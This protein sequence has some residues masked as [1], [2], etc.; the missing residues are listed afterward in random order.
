MG[1]RALIVLA[2]AVLL[3]CGPTAIQRSESDTSGAVPSPTGATA[4]D[5]TDLITLRENGSSTSLVTRRVAS[6]EVVREIPDGALVPD[7]S[8][9]LTIE[10]GMSAMTVRKVDRRTG[11]TLGRGTVPG[12]WSLDQYQGSPASTSS[13]GRWFV[14]GGNRYNAFDDAA[15]KWIAHT[16]FAVVD[17]KTWRS[18]VIPFEGSYTF[19]AISNSGSSLYLAERTLTDTARARLRVYDMASGTLGDVGGD[20]IPD[21]DRYVR[22]P[23]AF[24]GGM[25]FQLFAQ[26]HQPVLLRLDVGGRQALVLPLPDIT[27]AP[28][29]ESFVMWSLLGKPDGSRLYAVNAALGVIDEIDPT[30]FTLVRSARI[31]SSS[32][33]RIPLR[34]LIDA[35]HPVAYAKRG[36]GTGAVF[37]PDGRTLFAVGQTG[38]WAIDTDSLIARALTRTG[39]YD[40]IA[41]SPDG[42]R[43][44]ALGFQ[45]GLVR[46]FSAK[47][48]ELLGTMKKVAF[49]SDIVAVDAG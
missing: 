18:S 37:A 3:T 49:P 7:R 20:A 33:D 27:A 48:G 16:S 15:G 17:T 38:L 1:H 24:V 43:L 25:R 13:D 36:I 30:S 10:P 44:Y 6:A 46:V 19:E 8:A 12:A 5:T 35:L 2:L 9:V 21:L 26:T 40:S 45:D 34:A 29:G 28:G 22:P 11:V 23:P 42:E 41:L 39:E 31:G 4:P 47:C 14:V 32:A